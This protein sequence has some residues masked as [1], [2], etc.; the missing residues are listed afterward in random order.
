[1]RKTILIVEDNDLNLRLFDDVVRSC[2]YDTVTTR[3]GRQ[4]LSLAR[5][6]RPCTVIMDIHLPGMSGLDIARAMRADASLAGMRILA[7]T[8]LAMK[9]DEEMIRAAGCDEYLSKPV[10]IPR[11][12]DTLARMAGDA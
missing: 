3:D 9:G 1:M 10:S 5:E 8:A 11:F 12:V 2:G 4:A 7:V 6:H